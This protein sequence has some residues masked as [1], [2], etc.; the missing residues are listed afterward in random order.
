MR[1]RAA[2]G[3]GPEPA[4][5]RRRHLAQ[6]QVLVRPLAVARIVELVLEVDD[7]PTCGPGGGKPGGGAG[8]DL[9]GEEHVVLMVLGGA[10]GASA[11]RGGASSAMADPP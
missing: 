1:Q 5:H 3:G 8:R 10:R 6:H 9:G 7:A 2:A 4:R 11:S